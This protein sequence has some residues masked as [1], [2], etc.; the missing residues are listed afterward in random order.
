MLNSRRQSILLSLQGKETTKSLTFF[1][2]HLPVTKSSH[3]RAP[4]A[5][6]QDWPTSALRASPRG[7]GTGPCCS[8]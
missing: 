2:C 1:L 7:L 6:E 3:Q 5:A 8:V 4:I